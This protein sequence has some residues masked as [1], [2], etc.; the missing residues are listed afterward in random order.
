MKKSVSS[1]FSQKRTK[2]IFQF[3][4]AQNPIAGNRSINSYRWNHQCSRNKKVRLL[5]QLQTKNL[6]YIPYIFSRT[7]VRSHFRNLFFQPPK[8]YGALDYVSAILLGLFSHYVKFNFFLL[9]LF[10]SV[11]LLFCRLNVFGYSL[12]IC[13]LVEVLILLLFYLFFCWLDFRETSLFRIH[14]D[15]PTASEYERQ[16][17]AVLFRYAHLNK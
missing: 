4:F 6:N 5:S 10:Y 15:Q 17:I 14:D 11:V 12:A 13:A 9:L 16:R 3:S 1:V 2:N 8:S 7:G